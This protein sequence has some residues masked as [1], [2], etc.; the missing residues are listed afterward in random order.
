MAEENLNI[1]NE[2]IDYH[3]VTIFEKLEKL[4]L[5]D[6]SNLCKN[7]VAIQEIKTLE[8]WRSVTSELL[9]TFIYV[10]IVCGAA[11]GA[12]VGFSVILATSLSSGF[13]MCTLTQC[14]DKFG[15]YHPKRRTFFTTNCYIVIMTAET[16]NLNL[17]PAVFFSRLL[18]R[19]TRESFRIN[20]NGH[21]E[22]D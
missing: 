12:G 7:K 9:A 2:N 18:S 15:K 17:T 4:R 16:L 21:Y 3:L 8:F 5:Y 19:S 11:V 13:T 6:N 20:F 14:F 10:F 22:T 1:S